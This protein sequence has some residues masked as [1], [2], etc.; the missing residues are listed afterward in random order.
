MLY[1]LER[2][3]RDTGAGT[4]TAEWFTTLKAARRREAEWARERRTL[5]ADA[6]RDGNQNLGAA[7]WTARAAAVWAV[8]RITGHA[9]TDTDVIVTVECRRH[10]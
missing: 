10:V 1:R 9:E 2:F 6:E 4:G 3:E 5:Q 7:E 8:T